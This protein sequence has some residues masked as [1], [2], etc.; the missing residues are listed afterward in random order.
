MEIPAPCLIP[1]PKRIEMGDAFLILPPRPV[2]SCAEWTLAATAREARR[3][4]PA[5]RFTRSVKANAGGIN[6]RIA[7][8]RRAGEYSLSVRKDGVTIA[9]AD[10]AA[11]FCGLQTLGQII[12]GYVRG[13]PAPR[14]SGGLP[15]PALTVRDWPDMRDRGVYYDVCRGRV[16]KLERLMELA[17]L[18]SQYKVNQLQL[19]I[20]HTFLFR[21]HP[22]IGRGASPLTAEDILAL[23]AHCRR[24]HIELVPSLACFGHLATVL[25]HPAYRHLAE[26]WAACR[27][28]EPAA[29]DRPAWQKRKGWSLAPGNPEV[30]DFLDSLFSE[31]L[32]LF[33]SRRFNVCCDETWDLGMGQS[34]ELCRRIGKG[35][36]YLGHLLKL[37]MLAA[38]YGK[39]VQFWGDI[40]RHYPDLIPSIPRDVTVLDW[41]YWSGHDFRKIR[42]FRKAGL[43]FYACPGTSSW[44][45]LF[46]RLHEGAANIRGFAAAAKKAGAAGLLNTDWGDGGHHNFME[47]SWHGYLA[48]AESSWN[49]GADAGSFTS[50]FCRLFLGTADPAVARAVDLFGD[51]SHLGVKGRYQ[52]VWFHVFFA[53]PGDDLFRTA[54]RRG[55]TCRCGRIR[56]N[57]AVRLDATLGRRVLGQLADVR[58]AFVA[59]GKRKG[60]D[61]YEVLD[62]WIFAV[63]TTMHAARKL[64]TLG[65]GGNNS[66]GAR[67]RLAAEMAGLRRRFRKLWLARN[68]PSEIRITLAKY[69]R[70]IAAL[71]GT[72]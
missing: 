46:P 31:F 65:A 30:Y 63:D 58:K 45:S 47:F 13:A 36:L 19:Y 22:D 40:I 57:V 2:V 67:S 12:G 53:E 20:E 24:F 61:P 59:A 48:G 62:Y 35:R 71:K 37:R 68:R 44:V 50:R 49:T 72:T 5:C 4:L 42:D 28:T 10:P 29:A 1:Q 14:T 54:N 60:S 34:H 23:D 69:D 32:P 6:L 55:V 51:I 8:F 25:N 21:G 18:L 27:Y 39:K 43:P 70:A 17:S 3:F 15:I 38:K 16:P 11:V 66:T 33:S 7:R 9:G 41:N 56:E 26:D 64:A 52:S